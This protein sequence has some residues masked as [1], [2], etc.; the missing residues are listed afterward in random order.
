MKKL[1]LLIL[2]GFQSLF[3]ISQDVLHKWSG[4]LN[5][6]GQ[7]IEL[8]L[9][10]IQNADKT[11]SS[12]WDIPAQK[13]KGLASSKTELLNNQL[14]VEIKMIGASYSGSLNM[15]GDK[16]DGAWSQ[17][18]MSFPLNMETVKE[19]QEEKIFI[20][21]QTPKP[22]F[23]YNVKDFVYEGNETKLSYGAT[24]TYPKEDKKFPLIILI[25]GSGRQDR[26]ETIF[27]HKPFAVIADYLTK[28][29]YAVLRVDDR[30][31]GKSTGDFSNSTTADFAQDVEEHIRYAKN[32]PM[33][34]TTQIGL[35]GHSEGGLIAPMVAVRNK[36]V[37]F[38]ILLAGPGVEIGE[39]MAMQNEM[40]LKSAG[41]SQEAINT[42]IPLYKN[43]MKTIVSINSIQD[44]NAKAIEI[45]KN[46][47]SN[48]DK[49]LVKAT[50]NISSES[51]I[52][53]FATT[54]SETLST[55][56]WKY[57][58][59]YNPQIALQK[60]KCP[61][62]AINGSSDI[63]VPADANL[64]AIELGL[65]KAGNKKGTTMK[66]DNLNHLFQKCSKCTVQEYGELENTI[67]PEVL[68]YIYNWLT[69]K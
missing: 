42:Y 56:W 25:T 26:D 61:V 41:I 10:L 63:Q 37:S 19:G 57:F 58:A 51:D 53:K 13:V 46:W 67:E 49:N 43:L 9:N 59:S 7:K 36:S 66:F 30:G 1:F 8:R 16:V 28:K 39:L 45:V 40:V 54:M 11:Y 33:I 17:S 18:G 31:A 55:K 64:K 3:C 62:L 34:D 24:L 5:A 38:V 52:N 65:K 2:V 47:Y 35:L 48:T 20:K 22:P 68:E 4:V 69:K 6:G 29:G 60:L 32:L 21:P 15:S 23:A 27:D 14:S 44:A 50:T 12:N